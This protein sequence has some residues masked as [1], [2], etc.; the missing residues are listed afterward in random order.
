[1][2]KQAPQALNN[3][4]NGFVTRLL[5]CQQEG[6]SKGQQCS[7]VKFVPVVPEEKKKLI[8]FPYPLFALECIL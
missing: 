6:C 5:T 3:P 4:T 8:G 7:K 2:T 1:L